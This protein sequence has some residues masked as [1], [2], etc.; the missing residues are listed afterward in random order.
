MADPRRYVL[1]RAGGVV[2][3]GCLWDGDTAKWQPPAGEIAVATDAAC[4]NGWTY[5]DKTGLFTEPPAAPV[6]KTQ[7]EKLADLLVEKQIITAEEA[8]DV[9][10]RGAAAS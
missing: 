3:A 4:A 5:D 7:A 9:K 2:N 10:V 6:E 1:V 8:G